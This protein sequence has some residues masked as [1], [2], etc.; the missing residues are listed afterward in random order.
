M[1]VSEDIKQQEIFERKYQGILDL[2]HGAGKR[3]YS[4]PITHSV[5]IGW[6]DCHIYKLMYSIG[7]F[8]Q[9]NNLME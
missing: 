8:T 3:K 1:N 6:Y 5:W 7:E 2:T 4:D 9:K